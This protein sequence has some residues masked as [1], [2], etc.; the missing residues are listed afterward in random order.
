MKDLDYEK[1]VELK[2]TGG[3]FLPANQRASELLDNNRSVLSFLE[4][5]D[6]DVTFHRAYFSL[7][8][9]IYDWLTPTFKKQIHKDKFY[10][11][12]KHLRKEYDVI[13]TFKDGT[14]FVEYKSI[15]FG[16]MSQAT[17]VEYVK[18]QLPDIYNEIICV[19]YPNKTTSD[20]IIA[21]IEDEYKKF[22]AKL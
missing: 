4:V 16:R 17:F 21:S 7:I 3:G 6:R 18:A 15:S 20:R 2:P 19:L 14:T 9:F 11:F 8:G 12:I 5:T 10:R 22:L 13:M 1:I